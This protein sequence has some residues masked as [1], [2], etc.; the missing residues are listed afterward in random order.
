MLVVAVVGSKAS[1]QTRT[2]R[3]PLACHAQ[4]SGLAVFPCEGGREDIPE[5][6]TTV[7]EARL[8]RIRR[9]CEL[10]SDAGGSRSGEKREEAYVLRCRAEGGN[11]ERPNAGMI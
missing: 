9:A 2:Y 7:G 8:A 6:A 10:A 3:W 4:R 1:P 11:L 5:D